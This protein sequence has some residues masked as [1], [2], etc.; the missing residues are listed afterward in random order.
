MHPT[1]APQ[2]C[3]FAKTLFRFETLT[4]L[5]RRERDR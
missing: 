3:C 1:K 5:Q 4:L 2:G